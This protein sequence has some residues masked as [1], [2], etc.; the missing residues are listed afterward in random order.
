MASDGNSDWRKSLTL[1]ALGWRMAER[2]QHAQLLPGDTLDIAFTVGQNDHPEFGGLELSLRDFKTP[3]K[4]KD[5]NER[6]TA[7][8]D[9][10]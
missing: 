9:R 10:A 4:A 7:A 5:E 1:D 8:V 3:G 6:A 2:F